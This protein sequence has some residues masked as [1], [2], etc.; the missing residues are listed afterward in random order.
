[1]FSS[2]FV[3]IPLLAMC[4]LV[5]RAR[6][7]NWVFRAP[8]ALVVFVAIITLLTTHPITEHGD[9]DVR[10]LAPLL[11]LGIGI[12]ILA[13]WAVEPMKRPIKVAVLAL[14]AISV[15]VAPP[16]PGTSPLTASTAVQ[17]YHELWQPQQEPFTPVATWINSNVPSGASVYVQPAYMTYPLMF[18]AG[19][20]LYAWQLLDP[21]KPEYAHVSEALI[22]GRVAPEYLVAFGPF[23]KAMDSTRQE[24]S[25]R[26]I[27]Y[28]QVD[29]VHVFWHDLFR[30]ETIWRSFVTVPP[31]PGDEVYIYRRVT[32]QFIPPTATA[33]LPKD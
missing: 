16:E 22:R 27:R 10:Y 7:S 26:G 29:T 20:A 31:K 8:T 18:H 4:P 23:D 14:A 28:E 32:D 11:P 2:D 15:F 33:G 25:A 3:I 12:A 24:L 21:P 17:F 6:K 19:K 1:M 9:A 30:P 13:V 5:Y